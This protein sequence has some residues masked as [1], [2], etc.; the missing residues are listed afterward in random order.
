MARKKHIAKC[1]VPKHKLADAL[2]ETRGTST[3]KCL[4]LGPPLLPLH[5][6][7]RE[8]SIVKRKAARAVFARCLQELHS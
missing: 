3:L 1:Q 5:L 7:W 2:G 6:L 8:A 4:G